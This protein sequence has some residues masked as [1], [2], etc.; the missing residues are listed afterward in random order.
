MGVKIEIRKR[1]LPLLL[2]VFCLCGFLIT[3]A[4]KARA[5][6]SVEE[7]R[8]YALE[9]W[10]RPM[11]VD[12][13]PL[14][15]GTRFGT[16]RSGRTHAA[17]D[18][19]VENGEGTLVYAMADGVVMEYCGDFYYGTSS[20]GV[21]N[22]D[23]SV[24][25]YCEISTSLR[26]GDKVTQGQVIG[27]LIPNSYTG[28]C[29]LH[30]ELY[31]GT[32]EGGLTDT[33]NSHYDYISDGG[34]LRRSD[35]LDPTFLL[36]ITRFTGEHDDH[37]WNGD[38]YCQFCGRNW[39]EIMDPA[40][41]AAGFLDVAVGDYCYDAVLWAVDNGVSSGSTPAYF[42]TY[43]SC[44]RAQTLTMLW[45]AAGSP[46][47]GAENPFTDV[48]A[49]DYCYDAVRW[50]YAKGISSGTGDG[51]FDPESEITRAQALLFLWRAAGSPVQ[52]GTVSFTDLDG[53]ESFSDAIEWATVNDIAG[54]TGSTTFGPGET[55]T[56]GQLITFLYRAYA[57]ETKNK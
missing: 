32:R 6:S 51:E 30:L 57:A 7:F 43:T 53:W 1:V 41:F 15:A 14:T 37:S 16:T 3:A 27:K 42:G 55:C 34:Y 11:L 25:R 56:R 36:G 28:A 35:L 18:M 47:S 5:W 33:G 13:K 38:G 23:G 10:S 52:E 12:I 48:S 2:A 50:A 49:S 17:V 8:E 45:R 19:T 21:K 29:M 4:P 9:N 40:L 39:T 46:S 20:I 31:L 44:T 24:L 54:G 22:T 26:N